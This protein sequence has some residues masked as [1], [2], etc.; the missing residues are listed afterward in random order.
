MYAKMRSMERNEQDD[1]EAV[2]WYRAAAEQGYA[3]AQSSLA[4]MYA[5]GRGVEQDGAEAQRWYRLAA[6]QGNARAQL[7][8]RFSEA[9]GR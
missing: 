6:E 9:W 8:L 2:R 5:V 3:F 1:I 7:I 4:F